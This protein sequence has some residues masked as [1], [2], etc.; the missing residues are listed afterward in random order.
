MT[1]LLTCLWV[2][3]PN[4]EAKVTAEDTLWLIQRNLVLLENTSH[5]IALEHHKIAWPKLNPKLKYLATDDYTGRDTTS[6]LFI[7]GIL[8]KA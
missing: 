5:T 6:N 4:K 7:Q 2:D 8:K 3:L 1:S